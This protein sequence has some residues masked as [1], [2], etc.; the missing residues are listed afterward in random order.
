MKHEKQP[1]E[2]QDNQLVVHV[3]W[4]HGKAPSLS[5]EMRRVYRILGPMELSAAKRYMTGRRVSVE[6]QVEPQCAC[7]LGPTTHRQT[8]DQLCY[9]SS[10]QQDG[11][12]RVGSAVTRRPVPAYSLKRQE[13]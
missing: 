11:P 12:G 9:R 8:W 10:S 5:S 1:Q 2:P 6:R 7:P 3:V 13:T 4:N